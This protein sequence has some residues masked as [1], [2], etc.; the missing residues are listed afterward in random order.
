M[1]RVL[2]KILPGRGHR[3]GSAGYR[4]LP[5]LKLRKR[6]TGQLSKWESQVPKEKLSEI[7]VE[8]GAVREQ[9]KFAAVIEELQ[10]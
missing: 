9:A 5:G 6:S 8:K 1:A 10:E 4:S 7:T 2:Q 3:K